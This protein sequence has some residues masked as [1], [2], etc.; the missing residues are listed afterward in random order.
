MNIR[1]LNELFDTE[2]LKA[3]NEIPYLSG[4]IGGDEVLGWKDF[5]KP[6]GEET[7]DTLHKKMLFRFPIL[8]HFNTEVTQ[9]E[10]G[11]NAHCSYRTSVE[12]ID[13][14]TYYGQVCTSYD[15]EQNVYH[16]N[17]I[18]R[19]VNDYNNPEKWITHTMAFDNIEDVYALTEAF[20]TSCSK[21]DII[22]PRQKYSLQ[23]N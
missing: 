7:P 21:L 16:I 10:G 8:N 2:E 22:Q 14:K 3:D 19:N 23:A 17:V 13:G 18:L 20:L 1:K 15:V 9:L 4:E 12:P 11:S 5:S 6:H